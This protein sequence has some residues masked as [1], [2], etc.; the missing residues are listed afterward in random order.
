LQEVKEEIQDLHKEVAV[1]EAQEVMRAQ[2]VQV[3]DIVVFQELQ[4]L[5]ALV[6][7]AQEDNQ[8]LELEEEALAVVE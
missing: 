6:A 3:V 4:V 2:E 8:F 7:V 1:V 5:G